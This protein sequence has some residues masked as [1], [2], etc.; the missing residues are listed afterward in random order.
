MLQ[1]PL[2][3]KERNLYLKS[4]EDKKDVNSKPINKLD[5]AQRYHSKNISSAPSVTERKRA[6]K[7]NFLR[8][9]KLK[10]SGI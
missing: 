2:L 3:I 10:S 6:S 5:V 9:L 4:K 8:V 1:H 7:R